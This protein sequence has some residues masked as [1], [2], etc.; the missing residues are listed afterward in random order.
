MHTHTH[1]LHTHACI[2]THM[3]TCTHTPTHIH[4]HTH[5][6]TLSLT[7]RLSGG[8]GGWCR[9]PWRWGRGQ[10]RQHWPV[11]PVISAVHLKHRFRKMGVA[12]GEESHDSWHCTTVSQWKVDEYHWMDML[13]QVHKNLNVGYTPAILPGET[14]TWNVYRPLLSNQHVISLAPRPSLQTY[15]LCNALPTGYYQVRSP[16]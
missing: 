13:N 5:T 3:H 1:T 11:P 12:L 16:R 14:Q 7:W 8:A 6:H 10:T 15:Y 2:H 9:W 4:T